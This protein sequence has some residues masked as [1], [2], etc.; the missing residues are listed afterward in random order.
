MTDAGYQKCACQKCRGHIE[1]PTSSAGELV[2]CPH[3]GAPTKLF[4][5]ATPTSRKFTLITSA[6]LAFLILVAAGVM[7]YRSS[8][9]KPVLGPSTLTT[10]AT[11]NTT[12][13]AGFTELNDFKVGQVTLR[14]ADGNGLIY[15][16]GTVKNDTDRQRFGVKI[17]LDLLDAQDEKIGS[18]SDY[19]AVM[20]PRKQWQ[21]R[22]LLTEP[23]TVKAKLAKID[24]QK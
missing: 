22:A 20:E 6:V 10:N 7:F 9:P 14:K 17:E 19:V 16:V 23:K 2:N 8:T 3:C 24:E 4:L 13:S 11:A 15:A 1:F 12:I 18:A 21:F 5:P